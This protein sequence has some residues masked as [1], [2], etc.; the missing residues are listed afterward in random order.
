MTEKKCPLN[1]PFTLTAQNGNG[2]CIHNK[3]IEITMLQNVTQIDSKSC[4]IIFLIFICGLHFV[5]RT[6][7]NIYCQYSLFILR[8]GTFIAVYWFQQFSPFDKIS[9]TCFCCSTA[10]YWFQQFSPFDKI[11]DTCFCCSTVIRS[12]NRIP[13]MLK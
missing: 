4:H 2:K 6:C 13:D 7:G 12:Y 3:L 10:V 5:S 9:D 1:F 8:C 11:S